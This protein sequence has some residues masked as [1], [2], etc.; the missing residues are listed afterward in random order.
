MSTK[1]RL[2]TPRPRHVRGAQERLHEH[3]RPDGGA[4]PAHLPLVRDLRPRLLLVAVRRR[5]Q[6]DHAG[7]AGHRRA[8]RHA[9]LHVQGRDRGVRGRHPPRRR[10]RD[11]RPVPRRHALQRRAHHPADLRRRRGHRLRAVQRPLGRRRR[12]GPGLVRHQR[13][14][15]LRRGPAHP[16]DPH[17]GQG[18]VPRRRRA[19]VRLQHARAR[20]DHRRPAGAGRGDARGRARDPPAGREVRQADDRDRVRRGAGLRREP[21]P[22]PHRRAARRR[23]G[24][25]GLHRLRP[26]DRRGPDPDQGQDDDRGRPAVATT[27]RARIRRSA[28]SSTPASAARSRA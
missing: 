3:R 2:Y 17:L 21:H 5:G 16:A 9:A 18:Q 23:L 10:V 11:Q 7:L 28:R 12:H 6:H 20:H 13:Q 27:S 25:R 4:D 8:R 14:G 26:V 22:P 19:H 24:D 1:S 15:A